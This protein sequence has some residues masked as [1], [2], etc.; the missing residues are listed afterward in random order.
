MEWLTALDQNMLFWIQ[1]HLVSSVFNPYMIFLS[2]IGNSGA[3]WVVA[4]I[5]LLAVKKYRWLG[6][7]VLLALAMS[8]VL[9]NGILKPLAAR[10]R[11]CAIFPW[12]PML[13]SLPTDYSFPSGHTFASFAA[14]V[15]IFCRNKQIG[16][17][18][19]LLATGIGFSRMYLFV[20]Y[21]SDVLGGAL[22]GAMS[23]IVADRLS[24]YLAISRPW[25]KVPLRS[26]ISA[27][28]NDAVIKQ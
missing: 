7:A 4:G 9:G 25:Q 13:V 28:K 8:L 18:A 15:A 1:N 10:L 20:H 23:G 2:E 26:V 11:P 21:P 3:I 6:V 22:L 16:A 12:M 19:L 27:H 5:A 14:A 24:C 17:A